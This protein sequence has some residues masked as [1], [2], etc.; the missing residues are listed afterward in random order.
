M[1]TDRVG[2]RKIHIENRVVY[3]NGKPIIFR[4]VNR[5]DFSVSLSGLWVMSVHM[6]APLKNTEMDKRV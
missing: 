4:G 2:I 1:I 3:F 5:H 6:D